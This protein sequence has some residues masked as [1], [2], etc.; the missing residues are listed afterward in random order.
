MDSLRDK[1]LFR[2]Q[3]YINGSWLDAADGAT[4]D[5]DN[6]AT[7]EV[8]GRVP[9]MGERETENAISAAHDAF[10]GWRGMTAEQ[11]GAI[12]YR[13]HA[14]MLEN[15]EDLARLM[16]LEQGKPLAEAG[17]EI[18]YA[19]SFLRC[20]FSNAAIRLRCGSFLPPAK[21][22]IF[23]PSRTSFF[24]FS[25]WDSCSPLLRRNLP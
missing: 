18:A 24:H 16:T 3:C 10:P 19:A 4:L 14:L 12:L 9:A 22:L 23:S 15:Q 13:W 5:V 7:G 1:Q 11:R 20:S 21:A 25:R 8:L 2:Q 17:G 6:P